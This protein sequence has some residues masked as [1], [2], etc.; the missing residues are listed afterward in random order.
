MPKT[1]NIRAVKTL[2]KDLV[3]LDFEMTKFSPV[4]IHHPYTDSSL[5]AF[6][7]NG[8]CQ[9]INLL[10]DDAGL[11]KWQKFLIQTIDS[12]ETVWDIY[13]KITKPYALSFIQLTERYLSPEDLGEILRDAWTRIEFVSSNP[14]FTQ[15]QFVKLFRK[16]DMQTL[17]TEAERKNYDALPEK[18]EIYRGVRKGSKKVKGMSWTSDFKVA[19]W[20]SKRFTAEHDRGNIYKAVI[21]KS[22]V[23][24]YFQSASES[25]IVVDTKGLRKIERIPDGA[26]PTSITK[27]SL[28]EIINASTALKKKLYSVKQNTRQDVPER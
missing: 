12:D 15:A 26:L 17:M 5:V 25:E 2:A 1:T 28:D 9:M 10:E 8:K 23:L 3:Y 21:C 24:A 13:R 18:I 4:L 7:G 27:L 22:D 16:C 14:V 11:K 20:F 19:E 6:Q